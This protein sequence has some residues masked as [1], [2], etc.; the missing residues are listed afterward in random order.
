MFKME[1]KAQ[2]NIADRTILGGAT[3]F[4]QIPKIIT[5]DNKEYKVIGL[6]YGVKPPYISL[7]IEEADVCL[8]GKMIDEE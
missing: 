3:E 1:I 6:S 5:I 4:D 8:I 7:E 2:F